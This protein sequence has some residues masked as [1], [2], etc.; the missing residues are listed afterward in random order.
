MTFV[1][2]TAAGKNHTE[3]TDTQGNIPLWAK[4]TQAFQKSKISLLS[5]LG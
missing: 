4:E 1:K 5:E 3:K 2:K